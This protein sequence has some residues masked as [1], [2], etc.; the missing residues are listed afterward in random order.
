V[1]GS[2]QVSTYVI[3]G[4]GED[5][6]ITVESCKRAIDIGVYPFIVPLRPVPGTILGESVPPP[7]DYVESIYRQVVP[8]LRGHGMTSAGVMAGCARCQACSGMAVLEH[9]S[10]PGPGSPVP[11]ADGRRM[12]PLQVA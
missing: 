3:L 4:M 8:H 9:E 5:P 7:R 11:P 6:A 1:F 10:G 2:G 12:L